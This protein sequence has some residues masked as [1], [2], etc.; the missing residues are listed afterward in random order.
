MNN[1][2]IVILQRSFLLEKGANFL[3]LD[4]DKIYQNKIVKRLLII[5]ILLRICCLMINSLVY[6]FSFIFESSNN[7]CGNEK[8]IN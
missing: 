2:V 1:F 8:D 3:A 5:F 4:E 6:F 7:A